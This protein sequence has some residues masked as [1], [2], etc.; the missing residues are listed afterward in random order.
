MNSLHMLTYLSFINNVGQNNRSGVLGGKPADGVLVVLS[1]NLL[2]IAMFVHQMAD[3]HLPS[4][5]Q[6]WR[7]LAKN[8]QYPI[9]WFTS[10]YSMSVILAHVICLFSS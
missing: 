10:K 9:Y 4:G 5:E 3:T 8:N 2:K 7:Y 1:S 6:N